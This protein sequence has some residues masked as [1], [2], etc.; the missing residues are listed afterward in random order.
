MRHISDRTRQK[1]LRVDSSRQTGREIEDFPLVREPARL[2]GIWPTY[3]HRITLAI[4][5]AVRENG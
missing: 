4:R 1:T 2:L 5:S 3:P